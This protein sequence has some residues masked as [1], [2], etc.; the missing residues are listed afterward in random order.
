MENLDYRSYLQEELRLRTKRNPSYSKRAFARD[1]NLSAPFLTQVL[2]G[3][4]FLG[5]ERAQEISN[6]F[7]WAR[8]KKNAFIKL[9]RY[10]S[11]Q[12]G[13]IRQE[14]LKE[15]ETLY[16][17]FES[18]NNK[19]K[20]HKMNLEDFKIISEWWHTAIY[21]LTS[22]KSFRDDSKWIAKKLGIQIS[23]AESAIERLIRVDL[24]ERAGG[25][26]RKSHGHGKMGASSSEAIR[27]FHAQQL[28]KARLALV[29]QDI[30]TR[31]FSGT[32]IAIDPKNIPRAKVLIRKFNEEIM[33]LLEN[34]NQESVYHFS[35]Q[36]YRL[37]QEKD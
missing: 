35:V 37:D 22:T 6:K 31:D 25:V 7:N 3:S 24:L 32:T 15:I 5:E 36:L 8:W 21:E 14:V 17:K 11:L 18:R 13:K 10:Q 12:D 33:K 9:V 30:N 16:A 23:D 1:L 34:G 19:I 26:L 28:E 27:S 4:R 2:L 20:F 29:Q